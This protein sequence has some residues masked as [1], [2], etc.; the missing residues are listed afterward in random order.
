MKNKFAVV[1]TS[2]ALT[3]F[4]LTGSIPAFAAADHFQQR[5]R[6]IGIEVGVFPPGSHNAITDVAGVAVGHATAS[7]GDSVNT[8]VT[9]ILPH[10]ENVYRNPVPAAVYVANGYGKMLGIA[11]VQEL[12]VL[13]TPIAL[14]CT[15]CVWKVADDL[16]DHLLGL[17]DMESVRSI[18][19]VVGETNDGFLNDIRNKPVSRADVL[20]AL[21]HASAGAVAEGAVGAGR[22]TVAFGWK[23]GIGTS[24]R[25]I[26]TQRDTFVVGVLVQSNFGGILT[27]GGAP[28]GMEL[29]RYAFRRARDGGSADGSIMIVVAVDAPVDARQLQ[30][31]ARRAMLGVGRTGGAMTNGSG[32]FVIAFSTN[33]NLTS[34]LPD[35]E[36]SPLFQAAAEATEEAIY[37]SMFAAET[38]VGHRGT[39]EAL[40]VATVLPILRKYGVVD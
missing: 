20:A 34:A 17:P 32:D 15:L 39:V 30:R 16:T 12:G 27:I 31:I 40:D 25:V 1:L 6:D 24:S 8:G 7:R 38:V 10:G 29:G 21:D 37:N 13:E 11:Q 36:L 26:E 4:A 9:V 2:F 22:G 35:G 18:N 5:A 19:V 14:T 28:V 23:G 3:A 33:R